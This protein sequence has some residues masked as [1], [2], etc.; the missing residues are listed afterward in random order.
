MRDLLRVEPLINRALAKGSGTHTYDDI[1]EDIIKGTSQLWTSTESCMVTQVID[2]P[3]KRMLH[4]MIGAGK[5][6][7]LLE[8]VE[9]RLIPFA[10]E[11][12]C[13]YMTLNGRKGWRKA[14]KDTG[15][16]ED[17]VSLYRGLK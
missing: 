2:F 16:S 17:Y 8:M 14:L 4:I 12:E 7:E 15:W 9:E 5:L 6:D 11:H 3:Q 10:K 13:D 1:A